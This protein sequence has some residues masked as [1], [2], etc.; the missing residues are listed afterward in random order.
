MT[1][2]NRQELWQALRAQGMVDGELPAQQ[3]VS[4]PWFVRVM[5]GIAG[6]IGAL[7]LLG[8]FGA[9]FAFLWKSALL[10]LLFGA[11][12][13]VAAYM[14]FRAA[15]GNDFGTQ[16]GLAVS[17]AGQVLVIYG[18][19]ELLQADS[20][21]VFLSIAAFQAALAYLIPNALHR[22]LTS[23]GAVL[24]LTLA[25]TKLGIP[26][27]AGACAAAALAWVWL[28][29][30]RWAVQ[31]SLWRPIGYGIA[32]ALV[33]VDIFH[34]FGFRPFRLHDSALLLQ[35]SPWIAT[36]LMTAVLAWA[37]RQLLQ[38]Q[39]I[40]P[41]S[42]IGM[43]AIGA[44]VLAGLISVAAPGVDIALLV[45]VLGFAAGN[46]ILM[47]LGVLSLLGFISHYYYQLQQTL[48]IKSLVLAAT[49][50]V[51]LAIR[52]ALKNATPAVAGT[53]VRDA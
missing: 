2:A 9:I 47:G 12:I 32:L 35:L 7:F 33:Q 14:L 42:G 20:L 34:L 6:W 1:Y 16:F 41:H 24:A 49:G 39:D 38:R 51:L 30:Q 28:A 26:G 23:G 44:A 18:L 13:C 27:L 11:G 19:S 22:L 37:S 15:G 31:G 45:L 29:P 52:W 40:A 25:L 36:L 3:T 48:L 43:A 21:P 50:I 46:R 8:A 5:L 10:S 4:S 17:I 53:E